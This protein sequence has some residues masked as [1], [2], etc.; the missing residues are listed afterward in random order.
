MSSEPLQNEYCHS[1]GQPASAVW[2]GPTHAIALCFDCV[3][4]AMPTMLAD[5][6]P[7]CRT[8]TTFGTL[9]RIALQADRNFWRS[10]TCRLLR[11]GRTLQ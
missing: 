11:D 8:A 5:S 2:H 6:A 3:L 9:K 1:C 10:V 7:I 4:E